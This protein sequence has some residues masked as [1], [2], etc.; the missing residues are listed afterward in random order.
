MGLEIG[1]RH[2]VPQISIWTWRMVAK[3]FNQIGIEKYSN[4]ARWNI[5]ITRNQAIDR[6]GMFEDWKNWIVDSLME[7]S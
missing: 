1:N 6:F 4:G 3:S 5:S 7:G 2:D